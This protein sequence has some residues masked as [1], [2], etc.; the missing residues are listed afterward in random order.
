MNKLNTLMPSLS[1]LKIN[2]SFFK[3]STEFAKA[4]VLS[5]SKILNARC[6]E[7]CWLLSMPLKND[8]LHLD[9]M[10]QISAH[11][12]FSYTKRK[13]FTLESTS[14]LYCMLLRVNLTCINFFSAHKNTIMDHCSLRDNFNDNVIKF[15]VYKWRHNDVITVKLIAAIQN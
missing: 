13:L 3:I 9:I 7:W 2:V 10:I 1:M 5:V 14:A 11:L 4:F 12:A 6:K 15:N 8:W